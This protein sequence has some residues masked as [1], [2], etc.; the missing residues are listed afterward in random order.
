MTIYTIYANVTED[1]IEKEILLKP[2]YIGFTG[3]D[4]RYKTKLFSIG[5][6]ALR[7]MGINDVPYRHL[8]GKK[9]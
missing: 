5:W 8:M 7:E 2:Y 1:K 6:Y 9:P 3:V 4:F